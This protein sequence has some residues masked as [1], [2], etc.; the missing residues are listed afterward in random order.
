M[1]SHGTT[2]AK[3]VAILLNKNLEC[4]VLDTKPDKEGRIIV[5]DVL[6]SKTRYTLANLYAPNSDSPEFF[7]EV[8]NLI[9][10]YDNTNIIIGGDFNLV[11]NVKLDKKGGRPSTHEKCRKKVLEIMENRDLVDV[12]IREHPT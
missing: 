2:G 3:G 4:N 7:T 6:I 5:A 9:D 1:F 8:L 10:C 11:L 12:W